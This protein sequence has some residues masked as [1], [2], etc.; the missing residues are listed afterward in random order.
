M[1]CIKEV[2]NLKL[3]FSEKSWTLKVSFSHHV[4]VYNQFE[5]WQIKAVHSLKFGWIFTKKVTF[6]LDSSLVNYLYFSKR[7]LIFFFRV[8]CIPDVHQIQMKPESIGVQPKLTKKEI[9]SLE[10]VFMDSVGAI[11]PSISPNHF[12]VRDH[13]NIKYS[14][15]WTFSDPPTLYVPIV[16]KNGQFLNG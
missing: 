14:V 6:K 8:F 9:I 3:S 13:S 2:P 5:C 1:N 4:S 7:Y 12:Q 16:S 15:S 10:N 11:V